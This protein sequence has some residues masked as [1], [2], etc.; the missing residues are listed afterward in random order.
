MKNTIDTL[1]NYLGQNS[2]WRGIILVAASFGLAL[3]PELQN[4]IIAA[5]LGL[6]GIINVLRNGGKK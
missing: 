6:V 3:E 2:T 1:L 5:A 4:H